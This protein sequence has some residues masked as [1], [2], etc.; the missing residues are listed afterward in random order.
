MNLQTI[1]ERLN[2]D[3]L[4]GPVQAFLFAG[5]FLLIGIYI[6]YAITSGMPAIPATGAGAAYCLTRDNINVLNNSGIGLLAVS[7]V[8]IAAVGILAYLNVFSGGQ[9]QQ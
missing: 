9:Q 5:V 1:K 3:A 7:L 6:L 2:D 4:V 8:V